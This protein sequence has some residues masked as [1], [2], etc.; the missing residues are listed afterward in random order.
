MQYCAH[1][2]PRNPLKVLWRNVLQYCAHNEP[3]NILKVLWRNVL[4]WLYILYVKGETLAKYLTRGGHLGSL[5]TLKELNKIVQKYYYLG[6]C[7]H[8]K[9]FN[10]ST[11]RKI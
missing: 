7:K 3:R 2:E 6:R 10:N 9:L 11:Y 5:S 4:Q 8:F 1:N